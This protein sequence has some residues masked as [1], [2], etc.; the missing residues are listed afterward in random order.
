MTSIVSSV[1]SRIKQYYS[2]H[3]KFVIIVLISLFTGT[4]LLSQVTDYRI[5]PSEKVDRSIM[6][7]GML[8]TPNFD[9]GKRHV[10]FII[11]LLF[12]YKTYESPY[13]YNMSI[14]CKF[15]VVKNVN[16][17][18]V[19]NDSEI[20][21]IPITDKELNDGKREFSSGNVFW[22]NERKLKIKTKDIESIK[23]IIELDGIKDNI[24]KHYISETNYKITKG[25]RPSF[26][27]L[28]ILAFLLVLGG[29]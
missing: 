17:K 25:S 2:S 14:S 27:L 29:P 12:S 1:I 3:K 7:S 4:T 20:I 15:D 22:A 5:W 10:K 18:F 8:I 21:D 11:P 6:D 9:K 23:L 24:T 16:G 13:K 26:I 28:D 19:I